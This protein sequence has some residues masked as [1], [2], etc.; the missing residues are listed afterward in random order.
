[1]VACLNPH[2]PSNPIDWVDQHGD[3]LYNYALGQ[4]RDRV[5]AEDL[6]Q[7]TFLAAFKSRDRFQGYSSERT[8]LVSILRH[9]ICDHFRR[10]CRERLTPDSSVEERRL[11]ES[12]LWLHQTAAECVS[13][14]RHI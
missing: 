6:V 2:S 12:M 9:K 14:S 4:T 7:E 3:Y 11:N 8:W 5:G 10:K 13:V 1:M